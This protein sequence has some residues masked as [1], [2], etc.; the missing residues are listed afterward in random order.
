M[1]IVTEDF[2]S[3]IKVANIV[4]KIL[5]DAFLHGQG[6]GWGKVINRVCENLLKYVTNI[7]SKI[8]IP[9]VLI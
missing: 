2:L 4:L 7:S 5:V 3:S 9:I 1:V 8:P 6:M